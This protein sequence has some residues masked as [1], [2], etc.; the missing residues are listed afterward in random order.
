M[1]QRVRRFDSSSDEYHKA[2]QLFLDHTD[3]KARARERLEKLV[4]GLP[5]RNVFIDAGAGTGKVTAW[6]EGSFGRTIAAEPNASL[7]KELAATCPSAEILG[8]MILDAK[9]APKADFVLASHVFYY[10][11]GRDWMPNLERLASWLAPQG[12]ATVILQ[13]RKTDCMEMLRHFLRQSFDLNLLASAF[14]KAHAG[15]YRTSVHTVPSFI[16][17]PD[18]ETACRVAEFMLNLLP[19]ADPPAMADLRSYVDRNFKHEGGYRFSCTQDFLEIQKL[20]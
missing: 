17:T 11:D 15:K 19:L 2:F 18:L 3:Q 9:I 20:G 6:L 13:N 5:S 10:I 8:D 1:T 4:A 16:R 12:M 14:D 7:R